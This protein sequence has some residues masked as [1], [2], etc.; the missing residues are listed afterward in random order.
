MVLMPTSSGCNNHLQ[1]SNCQTN[2]PAGGQ[3]ANVL[4]ASPG[5]QVMFIRIDRNTAGRKGGKGR[6]KGEG[7]TFGDPFSRDGGNG[8]SSAAP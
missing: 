4:H 3:E 6:G 2:Y 7:G 1:T 5:T 8:G